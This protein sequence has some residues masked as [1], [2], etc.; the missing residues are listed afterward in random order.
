MADF[1]AEDLVIRTRD[2][3]LLRVTKQMQEF[4]RS[5]DEHKHVAEVQSLEKNAEYSEKAHSH[6][7]EEKQKTIKKIKK[8]IEKKKKENTVLD[9][10][11]K[12][13]EASF[14]IEQKLQKMSIKPNN[15][16]DALKEIFTRK[17]LSDLAKSQAQ[18]IAIL[19]EEVQRLRLRTFPAFN[20]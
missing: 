13:L 9:E 1:Q 18:D 2:I 7:M 17:R 6:R 16:Q 14:D 19:R 12:G 20:S 5:G 8:M 11:V 3:Q 4:I 15:R 10:Q